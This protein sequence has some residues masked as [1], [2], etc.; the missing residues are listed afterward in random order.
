M[1]NNYLFIPADPT[2][3]CSFI[4]IPDSISDEENGNPF[5][6]R[7]DE[8]LTCELYEC[9]WLYSDLVMLVD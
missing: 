9:V 2:L 8:L 1:Q 4:S 5:N 3:P 7:V 6:D